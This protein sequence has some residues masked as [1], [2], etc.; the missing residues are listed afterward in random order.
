MVTSGA[1]VFF[2]G[3]TS[4]RYDVSVELTLTSLRILDAEGQRLA[5]WPYSELEQVF[6]PGDVLRLARA[7]SP[8]LARLEIRDPALA[9]AIDERSI[10][11]DRT[12]ARERRARYKVVGWTIAATLSLVLIAVFGIP[13]LATRLAPLVPLAIEHR[14]GQAVDDEVRSM[15]DTRDAG[16]AFACGNTSSERAGKAALDKLVAKLEGAAALPIPLNVTVVRRSEANAIALPGGTIYVFEG[17]IDKAE[18]ADELAG[19]LAHE[20]GHVARRDGTRSVLQAAGLSFLFGMLLGDFVGGGAVVIA[21][22][23]VLQSSYSRDVETS[24]DAYS[25]LLMTK[26]EADPRALGTILGRIAGDKESGATILQDHPDTQERRA[27]INAAARPGP[28]KPLLDT[29]EWSAL[30]RLCSAQKG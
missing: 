26:L 14:L 19:V 29:A 3:V 16:D 5:D 7:D 10:P 28:T 15:L 25:V 30:K 1:G 8:I 24:A 21:A 12:G 11:V 2:D 6:A 4:A 20:I 27:T 9:A 23:T 22:R 17:L 18:N 13:A